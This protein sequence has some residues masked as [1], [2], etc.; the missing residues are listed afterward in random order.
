[1]YAAETS[2]NDAHSCKT[3]LILKSFSIWTVWTVLLDL[4]KLRRFHKATAETYSA[5]EENKVSCA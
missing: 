1:M 4:N 2:V 5:G 3:I